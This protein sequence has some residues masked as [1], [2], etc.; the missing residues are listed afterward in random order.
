MPS[1]M[2]NCM[3]MQQLCPIAAFARLRSKPHILM[4][5]VQCMQEPETQSTSRAVGMHVCN[6]HFESVL[7]LP[8]SLARSQLNPAMCS[9]A[10]INAQQRILLFPQLASQVWQVPQNARL[11]LA[12]CAAAQRAAIRRCWQAS[13]RSSGCGLLL[14]RSNTCAHKAC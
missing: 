10:R 11:P 13:Q 8:C 14:L 3:G 4:S 5:Y 9:L 6:R 12:D 7:Q 1:H 2:R